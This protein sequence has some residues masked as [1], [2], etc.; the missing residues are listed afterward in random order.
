ME[1]FFRGQS[2]PPSALRRYAKAPAAPLF[3][4]IHVEDSRFPALFGRRDAESSD[5]LLCFT[6]SYARLQ[7]ARC[8]MPVVSAALVRPLSKKPAARRA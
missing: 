2:V 8:R 3:R 4:A 5:A 7:V 6:P 1:R